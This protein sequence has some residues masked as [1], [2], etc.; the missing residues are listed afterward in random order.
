MRYLPLLLLLPLCTACQKTNEI[1]T[2]SQT[3]VADKTESSKTVKAEATNEGETLLKRYK[4]LSNSLLE[5]IDKNPKSELVK[6]NASKLVTDGI[7][8]TELVLTKEPACGKYLNALLKAAPGLRDM[9]AEEIETGYHQDAKLPKSPK[10][11][12]HH[13][14][15]L[16]VHPATVHVMAKSTGEVDIS[17]MKKEIAEVLAHL[18]HI[19]AIF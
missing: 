9:K 4:T 1:S 15:D 3:D 6:K 17:A 16:V 18:H 8:L 12:C 19:N 2:P 14:K 7:R 11:I 5:E 10:D 13:A